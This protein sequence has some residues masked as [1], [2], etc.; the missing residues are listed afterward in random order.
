MSNITANYPWFVP[1]SIIIASGYAIRRRYLDSTPAW[2][3]TDLVRASRRSGDDSGRRVS[4]RDLLDHFTAPPY[5]WDANALRAACAVLIRG[6]VLKLQHGGKAYANPADQDLRKFLLDSRQFPRADLVLEEADL[7]PEL[8]ESAR[9]LL[10]KLT[11]RR[12]I[13]ETPA[14][15]ADAAGTLSADLLAKAE[16]L[17]MWAQAV[18]LPLSQSCTDGIRAWQDV[19]AQVSPIPRVR[20]LHEQAALLETGTAAI[21]VAHEFHA[22]H[23]DG[24]RTM[25]EASRDAQAVAHL[26]P[27]GGQLGLFISEFSAALRSGTVVDPASWKALGIRWQSAQV[28]R[29]ELINQWRADAQTAL[30]AAKTRLPADC[31]E[32]HLD[33]AVATQAVADLDPCA[34]AIAQAQ[35]L[36]AAAGLA[37]QLDAAMRLAAGRIATAAQAKTTPPTP[38]GTTP[39]PPAPVRKL[40]QVRPRD[41]DT[42]TRIASVEDWERFKTKLDTR[43]REALDNGYD[44]ELS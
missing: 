33:P 21:V 2:A 26:L 11:R 14:A 40:R 18:N 35:T 43:V 22:K 31:A 16:R 9:G 36:G 41:V 37:N 32:R 25:Q 3:L 10:I 38:T 15:I 4:G 1:E 7:T 12:N 27:A 6:G 42:V 23:A 44:V 30:D 8:L 19:V 13:D 28:E 5:G 29:K 20:L 39:P 24:F 34:V 17:G